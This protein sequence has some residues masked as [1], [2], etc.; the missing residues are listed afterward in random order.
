GRD[1]AQHGPDA[2]DFDITRRQQR[3]LAFGH[4]VHSCLG[5]PLARLEADIALRKLFARYPD[6]TLG[7]APDSLGPVPSMFSNSVTTLPVRLGPSTA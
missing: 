7:A 4:G 3:H 6:M 2:G 1:A 5:A